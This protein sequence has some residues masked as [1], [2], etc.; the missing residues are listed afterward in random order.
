MRVDRY[1]ADS[2]SV[3]AFGV[4]GITSRG[5]FLGFS[6]P[7]ISLCLVLESVFGIPQGPPLCTYISQP[8]DGFPVKRLMGSLGITLLTS[9]EL[10]SWEGFS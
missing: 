3:S 5:Y 8:S 1:T 4:A 7:V 9:K 6:W 10:S 2:E